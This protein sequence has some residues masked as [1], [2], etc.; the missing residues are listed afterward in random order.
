MPKHKKQIAALPLRWSKRGNLKVLLITSR[1]TKRWVM[2]KGWP[3]EGKKPWRAAEIEALEEAGVQGV[4]SKSSIGK[5]RYLK[6]L[7]DGEKVSCEVKLFPMY[8]HKMRKKWPEKKERTRRWFSVKAAA[9]RVRE[10]QLTAILKAI[11]KKPKLVEHK[12]LRQVS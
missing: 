1:E 6:K 4:M 2:P 12:A 3:M 8:V 7:S 11:R 5:Y 9:K 10:P